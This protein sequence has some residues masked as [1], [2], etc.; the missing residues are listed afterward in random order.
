[1]EKENRWIIH[2]EDIKYSCPRY[3]LVEYSTTDPAGRPFPYPVLRHKK[4][5]I[6]VCALDEEGYI[7]LVGQWRFGGG[8]YSWEVVEG[9]SDDGEAPLETAKRE[10]AEEAGISAEEWEY[11]GIIHPNNVLTD[12]EAFLFLARGLSF[13]ESSPEPEEF[14]TQKKIKLND[15]VAEILSGKIKDALTVACVLMV[16]AKL[17]EGV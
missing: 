16:Y 17:K 13:G 14:L 10:L 11:L 2:S 6:A 1:M 3:D 5:S 12:E 15:F 9:R 7:Y 4:R 8:Y